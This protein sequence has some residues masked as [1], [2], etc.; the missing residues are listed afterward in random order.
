MIMPDIF[1]KLQR[2]M[3]AVSDEVAVVTPS[4]S[5]TFK[6]L[7]DGVKYWR[8]NL[9]T[10]G[11]RSGE[12][13]MLKGGFSSASISALIALLHNKAIVILLAPT[14]YEKQNEFA[15]VGQAQWVIEADIGDIERCGLKAQH[16]LYDKLREENEPGLV[17]FSSGSTGVSKG[18][19]HSAARL[20][21]KFTSPGKKLRTLAFLL[22]DHIAGI[23]TLFYSLFNQST[24]VLPSDRAPAAVCK[25]IADHRVEVL[26]TAPSFLNLLLLSGAAADHDLTSLKIITYGSEMM[27]TAT[28]E[29]CAKIFPDVKLIQKYGTSEIGAL[30]SRSKSNRSTWVKIGGDGFNW[31]VVDNK[32]EIRA[33]TAM[34]GYLNA[35]SPFTEDG[36]FK[37]G[38]EVE[39]D[40]DYIRF[41][42]RDSD[43]INVGGQK[44]YPA[45]VENLIRTIPEIEDVSVYGETHA[46]LGSAVVAK[47]RPTNPNASVKDLR[48]AIRNVLMGKIEPYKIPQKFLLTQSLLTSERGKQ[49]RR[50]S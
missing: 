4:G 36:Y 44:V 15:E 3:V 13:V 39:V 47:M 37:T 17:L 22:F 38:D 50:S 8:E 49:I 31:R 48:I 27:P 21:L 1:E 35:P 34:L 23:D 30:P 25:L 7:L 45:E 43:I 12:V 9:E 26:P 28:L 33:K 19:V 42:G 6:E 11:I 40:G 10:A 20:L 18:T 14:S 46:I 29:R 5:I 24:L 2:Q 32:L 16:P 41:L